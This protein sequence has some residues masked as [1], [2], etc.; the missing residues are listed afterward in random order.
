MNILMAKTGRVDVGCGVF[1]YTIVGPT[2]PL[3]AQE[4]RCYGRD[5]LGK[6]GN[7]EKLT[8]QSRT[9]FVCAG[10]AIETIKRDDPSTNKHFEWTI[11]GAPYQY[12]IYWK[13]GCLLDYSIGYSEVYPANPLDVKDP[14]HTAC[15]QLLIDDY[16]QCDNGGAGG[17]IQVGCLVYEFKAQLSTP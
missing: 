12:N 11:G 15:Q 4:R 14:G 2:V 3:T 9:G 17:A 10:T 13:E 1:S 7:I 6:H 16:T 8:Q 5:E